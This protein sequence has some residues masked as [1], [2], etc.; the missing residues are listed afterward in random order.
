[1]QREDAQSDS[2]RSPEGSRRPANSCSETHRPCARERP[3]CG[4]CAG[5]GV[6]SLLSAH[7]DRLGVRQPIGRGGEEACETTSK[8]SY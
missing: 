2:R 5:I 4:M 1:M 3:A 8:V 7:A 6:R